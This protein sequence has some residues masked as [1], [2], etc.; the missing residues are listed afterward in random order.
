[1]KKN[2]EMLDDTCLEL[3]NEDGTLIDVSLGALNLFGAP[4]ASWAKYQPNGELSKD[5]MRVRVRQAFKYGVAE[6]DWLYK[7]PDGRHIDCRIHM[8]IVEHSGRRVARSFITEKLPKES[9]AERIVQQ[10]LHAMLESSPLCTFIMDENYNVVD[11]NSVAVSMFEF[12]NKEHFI[13]SV[14]E[15]APKFTDEDLYAGG[16]MVLEKVQEAFASGYARFEW[17]ARTLSDKAVPSEFT[18]VRVKLEDSIYVIVYI[19]DLTD[20]YKAREVIRA[21]ESYELAKLFLDAAPFAINWVD[22]NVSPIDCNAF[23]TEL[24][25][26]ESKE[27]YWN[28]TH[29]LH[30]EL[31]PCGT[32]SAEKLRAHLQ[33]VMETGRTRFEWLHYRNNGELLPAEIVM[34]KLEFN[35][36]ILI[37]TY[38]ADMREIRAAAEREKELEMK[39]HKQEADERVK[40]MI[41]SAPFGAILYD[42][43]N[44][45][46]IDCNPEVIR[47]FKLENGEQFITAFK[48][49]LYD[50]FPPVQP[51]GTPT[52]EKLDADMDAAAKSGRFKT[53]QIFLDV[54]GEEI[55]AEVT[56]TAISYGGSPMFAFYIRDLREA[57]RAE[58]KIRKAQIAEES[59]RA[60]TNFLARMSHEIR[61]PIT[62]V[63]GISEIELQS[64]DITPRTEESFSKIHNSAT[65]LLGIVNDILDISKI[66]ASK[67]ELIRE[68]YDVS[69]MISDIIHLHPNLLR[70]KDIEFR[71][72]L[73]DNIPVHLIGDVLRIKQ[74]MNNLLSN[75]FKY[76]K[77]GSVELS[78][79]WEDSRLVASVCDTGF[80]M[81]EEQIQTLRNNEYTR[82]HESE[83]RAISGTGLG[84]PIVFNL[85]TMMNA[86]V[87]ITSEVGKGTSVVVSI[88]QQSSGSDVI[89]R[90][91]IKHLQQFEKHMRSAAKKFAVIPEPMPYGKV[92]VVDDVSANLY[93]A[94]GLLAFYDLQIETCSSGY[95][96]IDKVK[97]G[98]VY[99]II[100]VDYMMP[101]LN[102]TQT[103]NIIRE[104]GYDK[105]IVALTANALTGQEEE[106]LK[107]GYDDFISKPIQ[108]KY[109]NTVLNKL[110][111]DK[112]PP[113]VLESAHSLK[114][115]E[116]AGINIWQSEL[117]HKMRLDFARFN[118]N[119]FLEIQR[120]LEAGNLE[121]AQL[122]AHNL[123]GLAGLI[124]EPA[125]AK[126]A[127]NL[128]SVL[129]KGKTPNAAQLYA[130]KNETERVL[131]GIGNS[132]T[133]YSG[134]DAEKARDIFDRLIPLLET[135]DT[136]CLNLAD[137]LQT[138]SET[139]VLLKQIRNFDFKSALNTVLTL[140]ELF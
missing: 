37:A 129:A 128:E 75:A 34:E 21:R 97:N 70:G 38:S 24:F 32:P 120:E 118:K 116:N 111:R 45:A 18:I 42:P 90:E 52:Q 55:P 53:E 20:F 64:L 83:S 100:F 81:S 11:C 13:K 93:V 61:T 136:E 33:T 76:T 73:D 101:G 86:D 58:E 1:M 87:D 66:E 117:V 122:S 106:F 103:M 84:M 48:S 57:K 72:L 16:A 35:E 44:D 69:E 12:D 123:K 62:A 80:G 10:R 41:E 54:T 102:G 113:E 26:F 91:T 125:L 85:I 22:E 99:D 23:T 51:C 60:K 65:L 2:C 31:Q 82:F 50:F 47:L 14:F 56:I 131:A 29:K 92:L 115:Q 77:K 19:R 126:A 15:I 28:N 9:A 59:N 137:E 7:S 133:V 71:L 79:R 132:E 98:N 107:S 114:S 109:L 95:E 139:A 134:R 140:K 40:V 119:S 6:F 46:L 5:A 88:P 25:G 36:Q 108:T 30:P 3:W 39:L 121:N 8:Q 43:V 105:P 17:N 63:L 4:P 127:E 27:D 49:R 104:T 112:Q 130:L 67:M 110:I 78:W 135:S 124:H 74:I 94:R 89:T 96:A 138:L 68:P